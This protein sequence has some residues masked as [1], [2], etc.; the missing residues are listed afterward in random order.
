M[1]EVFY[2][3][4]AAVRTRLMLNVHN[5]LPPAPRKRKA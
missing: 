2:P 4:Y 1:Y 3:G 5:M